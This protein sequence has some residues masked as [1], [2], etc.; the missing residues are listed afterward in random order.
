MS[1]AP[2]QKKALPI[3]TVSAVRRLALNMIRVTLYGSEI[4]RMTQE[5]EG[6]NCKL[7]FPSEE[8]SRED[9]A[10]QLTNGPRPTVRTFTV[11]H[12]RSDQ[13]ELDIDFVDHGETGPASRWARSAVEGCFCGFGGPGTVKVPE[14][15]ADRYLIVADMSALPVAAATLEAMPR[16]A[17]G[18]AFFDVM[19]PDDHQDIDAPIGIRQHWIVNPK[20]DQPTGEIEGLVRAWDWPSGTL[21]TCIAGESGMIKTLRQYLLVERKMPRGDAYI[22]GYWKIG[23]VEDEHQKMKREET[24]NPSSPN[25]SQ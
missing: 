9:F 23:L 13:G 19:H 22:S 11:R 2:K 25:V 10:V 16:D 7:F 17:V 5:C 4:R 14:F 24:D 6:A 1:V 21:Q 20:P 18:D 15:Y 12:M 3:F 8:Q